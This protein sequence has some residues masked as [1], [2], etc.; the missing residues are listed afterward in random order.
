MSVVI[1]S[2]PRLEVRP[3]RLQGPGGGKIIVG[4]RDGSR[5]PSVQI[6]G[7]SV[8]NVNTQ[9]QAATRFSDTDIDRAELEALLRLLARDK[10]RQLYRG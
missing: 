3:F 9:P 2:R 4:A 6:V 10:V 8:Y 7:P 1:T 5:A